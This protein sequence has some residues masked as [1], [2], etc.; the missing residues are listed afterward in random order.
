MP[1]TRQTAH[2]G[3]NALRRLIYH[4]QWRP[5]KHVA[6]PV[7]PTRFWQVVLNVVTVLYTLSFALHDFITTLSGFVRTGALSYR[8][9]FVLSF[10]LLEP[11][12]NLVG[13]GGK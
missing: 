2:L 1:L 4:R 11:A 3:S 5:R 8:R 6:L 7:Q 10:K 13:C 12:A 9:P